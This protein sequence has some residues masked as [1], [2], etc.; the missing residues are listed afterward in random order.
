MWNVFIFGELMY[1]F[2]KFLLLIS[3]LFVLFLVG[4]FS[5]RLMFL[6]GFLIGIGFVLLNGY[7]ILYMIYFIVV[8]VGLYLL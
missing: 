7:D 3:S 2:D 5:F 1:L 8:L 6:N 4:V